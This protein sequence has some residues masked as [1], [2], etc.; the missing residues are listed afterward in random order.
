MTRKSSGG[1]YGVGHFIAAF[2]GGITEALG[3]VI[4]NVCMLKC[5]TS[6]GMPLLS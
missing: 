4:A 2:T 1:C 5:L 6:L 3:A